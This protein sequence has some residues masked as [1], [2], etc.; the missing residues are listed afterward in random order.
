MKL[1]GIK[2][3]GPQEHII[4]LPRQRGENLVFK[5]VAVLDFTD[6]E[7]L[8]PVPK[9]RQVTK[10]GGQK[11]LLLDD[12][13]YLEA[14]GIWAERKT[15]YSFLRSISATDNLEWETV[16]MGDPETWQNYE[17]ELTE[18]G[19][20]EP[21]RVRLLNVYSEVQGLDQR[22]IDEATESFLAIPQEDIPA[23]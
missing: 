15:H 22:K 4:V 23:E 3:E 14:L 19:L 7:N 21:E 17:T 12:P 2:I 18:A 9:P 13:K 6:F 10:P 16:N 1:K 5:F 8:C 11:S 20:T